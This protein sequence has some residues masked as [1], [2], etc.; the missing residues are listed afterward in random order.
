MEYIMYV[1]PECRSYFKTGSSGK[2]IKCLKCK[3]AYLLDLKIADVE[4]RKLGKDARTSRINRAIAGEHL[5]EE[6]PR[7]VE[8]PKPPESEADTT[9]KPDA[10]KDR[11]GVELP[12]EAIIEA[13][14]LLE[15]QDMQADMPRQPIDKGKLAI[16]CT[17]T[18][19]L[20]FLMSF[21]SLIL[22]IFRTRSEMST[23][24]D[25][26]AGDVID[27]GKYKGNTE[28]TVLERSDNELVVVSNY[29]VAK[30]IPE[31]VREKNKQVEWFNSAFMNK[32]FN[33][34]E[35]WN[36]GFMDEDSKDRMVIMSNARLAAYPDVNDVVDDD[37]VHLMCRIIVDE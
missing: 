2:K 24:I 7:S 1:C 18:V 33:I 17:V 21:T 22:P 30:A 20:L 11:I 37:G 8:P 16:V 19:G 36:I 6:I 23:L 5:R 9:P 12:D 15:E 32:A 31:G 34:Y 25:A 14:K 29:A 13:Q 10:D 4:W 27:Y 3:N 26:E 28:W 35:R